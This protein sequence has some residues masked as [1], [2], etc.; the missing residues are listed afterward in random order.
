MRTITRLRQGCQVHLFTGTDVL[1]EGLGADPK[2]VKKGLWRAERGGK[3]TEREM[4]QHRKF[5]EMENAI[6][7]SDEDDD[8]VP[9]FLLEAFAP[10]GNAFPIQ[11]G[12]AQA[13]EQFG[14]GG[15]RGSLLLLPQP[16]SSGQPH[17]PPHH[18]GHSSSKPRCRPIRCAIAPL[19]RFCYAHLDLDQ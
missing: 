15:G 13:G 5:S 8:F 9:I 16:K 7:W 4:S 10:T 6:V 11:E 19:W 2:T 3:D 1:I 17:D 14:L 12:G 18:T